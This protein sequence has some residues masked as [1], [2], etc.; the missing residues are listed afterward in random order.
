MTPEPETGKVWTNEELL[1]AIRHSRLSSGPKDR[2]AALL[3]V[4]GVAEV[5]AVMT[6]DA[7]RAHLSATQPG[8]KEVVD[9][10]YKLLTGLVRVQVF[11]RERG[12]KK[13]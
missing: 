2:K 13:D 8:D 11:C 1:E 7:R 3:D 4:A 12:W 5:L 6:G 10:L 9:Y